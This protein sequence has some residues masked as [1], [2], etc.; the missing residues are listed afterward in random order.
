MEAYWETKLF[1]ATSHQNSSGP[2]QMIKM[3]Q[4]CQECFITNSTMNRAVFAKSITRTDEL[5]PK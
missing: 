5:L 4:V 1:W 2:R 3:F